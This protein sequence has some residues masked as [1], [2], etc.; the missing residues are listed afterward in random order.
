[1][2]LAGANLSA[3]DHRDLMDATLAIM[4]RPLEGDPERRDAVLRD[5]IYAPLPGTQEAKDKA[6]QAAL[7]STGVDMDMVK[8]MVE[9][10][11]ARK[12]AAAEAAAAAEATAAGTP[13]P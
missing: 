1:M 2:L 9:A 7:Q 10:D 6:V 11:A 12:R 5:H 8:R 4:L 3:L 13:S